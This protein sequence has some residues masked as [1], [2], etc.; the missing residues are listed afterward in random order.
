MQLLLEKGADLEAKKNGGFSAFFMAVIIGHEPVVRTL[1]E[2]GANLPVE[3]KT[4]STPIHGA[5]EMGHG[6]LVSYLLDRGASVDTPDDK[7]LTS[8]LLVA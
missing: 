4:K 8:L 5:A 2:K 7:D 6:M 3:I 1:F